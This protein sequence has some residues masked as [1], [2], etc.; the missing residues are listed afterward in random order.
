MK[1][2]SCV[3]KLALSEAVLIKAKRF[4][5]SVAHTTNYGDANQTEIK[6][7]IN[8]HYISKL[9][10]EAV[11]MIMSRYAAVKGPD[12]EIYEAKR[13]S[14]EADLFINEL[15][16]AV[17][18]QTTSAAVR[19]GLSW[20][21]QSGPKRRDILLQQP[22]AWVAFVEY[23][24][25]HTPFQTC[26]VLPPFQVKELVFGEPKLMHLKGHKKVVYATSLPKM[27]VKEFV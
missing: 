5:E 16:L 18:T 9:G 27:D 8:D 10:E 17:K 4:A 22:D 25:L 15:P 3:Q 19:Y 14:W 26:F 23:D 13:K 12:Y 11:K 7:I 20:T 2:Y 1:F 6:K 24:D 21:F